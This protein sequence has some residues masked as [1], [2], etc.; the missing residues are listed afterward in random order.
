MDYPS[1]PTWIAEWSRGS[2]LS[3]LV[4][5][6]WVRFQVWAYFF[7]EFLLCFHF[8]ILLSYPTEDSFLNIF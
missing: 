4:H 6:A 2:R 1:R 3:L 7:S 5:T 8:L